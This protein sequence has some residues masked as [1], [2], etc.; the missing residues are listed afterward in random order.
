MRLLSVA[1]LCLAATVASAIAEDAAAPRPQLLR[2]TVDSFDGKE[3]AIKLS[4]GTEIS[5]AFTDKTQVAAVER[6]TFEQ[7]KPTD[8]IGVT[9]VPGTGNELRAEEVHVLPGVMGE[10]QY[11]WDH[12][13]DGAT[14]GPVRAGTMTNGTVE[15]P[16]KPERAGTMTNA[17]VTEGSGSLLKVSYHGSSMVDGK[18]E[19]RAIPGQ[20][21]CVGTADIRV[22]P[23][24]QIVALVKAT[25]ADL[26]PGLAV[27]AFVLTGPDGKSVALSVTTEKNGVKPPF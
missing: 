21:G 25:P 18:C 22:T 16:K 27:V 5:A 10:G 12:H 24:T 26:K 6:R 23:E 9:S 11:P 8:F 4:S 19:G 13:P 3:I 20:P 17:T 1:T 15:T 2:G 7:I 14:Q